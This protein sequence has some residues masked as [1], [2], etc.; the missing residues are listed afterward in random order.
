MTL[1]LETLLPWSASK[2]VSTKNGRRVLRTALPNDAFSA[3]WKSSKDA[4]KS[5]GIS[6][7][8]DER[9]GQWSVCWWQGMSKEVVERENAVIEASKAASA[10]IEVPAPAGLSYMPF[11]KAG[12]QFAVNREG[13][14]IGD[15]MGLGKTIQA[16]GVINYDVTIKKVLIV[17][18]ASLKQ[19]WANELRKWLVRPMKV[20]IQNSDTPWLGDLV[21]VLVVNYDICK[22]FKTQLWA[23]EWDLIAV[24]E[25]QQAKNRK[26]QRTEIVLGAP[27]RKKNGMMM[28]AETGLR[29]RYRL[30]LT[31]TPIEQRPEEI[32]T[33][34][35]WLDPKRWPSFWKFAGRYCGTVF[36]SDH[37]DTKG[38]SHLD[39][40]QRVLRSTCM[41]RRL[42][43]DVLTELP[44]KTRMLVELE[45]DDAIE[46]ALNREQSVFRQHEDSLVSAKVAVEVGKLSDGSDKDSFA[47]SVKVIWEGNRLAFDE[48]ARVRHET[49][50][51]KLP[52][53]IEALQDDIQAYGI[54][55]LVF[56]HHR[57]V[58]GP[59]H[60]AFPGSVL[61]T[62]ETPPEDRQA[63]VDRFQKDPSCGP[64]FGSIRATGEGLTLTA[65]QL[66]VFAEED[67]VPGK[68]AQCEDRA[69]RIGQ[70]GNVLVKHYVVNG[71][72]DIK[73]A[74]SHVRKQEVIDRALDKDMMVVE[75]VNPVMCVELGSVLDEK[76]DKSASQTI[77]ATV[78]GSKAPA[79][80]VT[81]DLREHVHA[82]LKRLAGCDY[83]RATEVNGVGFNKFDGAFGHALA[84][85]ARLTDKMVAAG[86]KLCVK[87]Q[88]QLGEAFGARLAEL[89]K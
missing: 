14:L 7:S 58:L 1:D 35:R 87:Y 29:G 84:E 9:T 57:D 31:G 53:V 70:K 82:G 21:D 18:K 3:A 66:V 10:N 11:Q 30:A 22:K 36:G 46:A 86:I 4:L 38:E 54:K 16:I 89:I 25:I 33:T 73:L 37:T 63:I 52:R 41:V 49:A 47:S 77:L 59:L 27:K 48:I 88:Q 74:K 40:L 12:I 81:D 42:K 83:D 60:A 68:I 64:F 23:R 78:G 5:A 44:A 69:H 32:Y 67:W 6:W 51:A 13:T 65:A 19:N 39:E 34:L 72:I 50:V 79:L 56:A 20:A 55:V 24:D 8:K 28:E 17:T 85:H 43:R 2:E 62:G 80:V 45:T 61:I 76:S 26:A 71:S 75:A 15:D